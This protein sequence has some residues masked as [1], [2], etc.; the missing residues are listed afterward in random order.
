[1]D[2]SQ[3]VRTIPK[4]VDLGEVGPD[5]L[6]DLVVNCC[7]SWCPPDLRVSC[8]QVNTLARLIIN[9]NIYD[10]LGHG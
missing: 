7:H 2:H 3:C 1:M 5:H 8:Y 4:D 10:T 9:S 6:I